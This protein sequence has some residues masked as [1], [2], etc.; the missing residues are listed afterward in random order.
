MQGPR[1]DEATQGLDAYEWMV[2]VPRSYDAPISQR[3]ENGHGA[4]APDE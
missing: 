1:G 3:G 2:L 4:G